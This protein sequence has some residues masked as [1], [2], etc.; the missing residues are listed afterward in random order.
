MKTTKREDKLLYVFPGQ[1]YIPNPDEPF[2]TKKGKL[3]KQTRSKKNNHR[4]KT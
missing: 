1:F 3:S 4:N 2:T